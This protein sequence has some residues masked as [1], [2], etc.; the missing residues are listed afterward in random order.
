MHHFL[1]G[2]PSLI[3]TFMEVKTLWNY[4]VIVCPAGGVCSSF[5]SGSE[6]GELLRHSDD[7]D[8]SVFLRGI[9]SGSGCQYLLRRNGTDH[10]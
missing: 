1:C 8:E 3:E 5:P 10:S 6:E 4:Y 7:G 9:Q 2:F